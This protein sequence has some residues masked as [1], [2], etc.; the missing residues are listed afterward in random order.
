MQVKGERRV[1]SPNWTFLISNSMVR[2]GRKKLGPY[3]LNITS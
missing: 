1:L 3:S 2:P